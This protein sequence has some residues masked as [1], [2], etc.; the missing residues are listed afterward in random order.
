MAT[1]TPHQLGDVVALRGDVVV[2]DGVVGGRSDRTPHGILPNYTI[3][4]AW[5]EV[6][7][8]AISQCTTI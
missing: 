7:I 5:V 8:R 4:H 3:I 6:I 2:G 1:T